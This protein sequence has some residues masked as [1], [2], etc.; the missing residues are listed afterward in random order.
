MFGAADER[1]RR[2]KAA[3]DE[4]ELEVEKGKGRPRGF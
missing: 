3:A 2:T 1:A 4:F